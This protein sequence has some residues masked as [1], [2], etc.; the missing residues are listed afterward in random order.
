MTW[1]SVA[2]TMSVRNQLTDY[3]LG[4]FFRSLP[5]LLVLSLDANLSFDSAEFLS[6]RLDGFERTVSVLSSR[7]RVSYPTEV[8]LLSDLDALLHIVSQQRQ[9]CEDLSYIALL[10]A[11]EEEQLST[12]RVGVVIS[13]VPGRPRLDISENLLEVLRNRAGFRWATIARNLHVSERTL[14]RRRHE[15]GFTSLTF[16]D[17]DNNSLDE[18]V[19]E[20]LRVTPRIGF[21]LVQGALRQRGITVQR[22]RILEAMRRVDPV[23]ITLRGSRSIVRR[24]Y[25]V[26]CPNAL[27]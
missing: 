26:P 20:I 19:R 7:L 5:D 15:F 25:S 10:H 16:S 22:R 4:Q 27:W 3:E 21:R 18:I 2:K 9:H 12:A 8:Q 24:R 13:G 11:E 17:I 14:R 23:M 1:I 6:R